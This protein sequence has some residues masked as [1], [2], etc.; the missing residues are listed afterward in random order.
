MREIVTRRGPGKARAP[1]PASA[2]ERLLTPTTGAGGSIAHVVTVVAV[3]LGRPRQGLE[4]EILGRPVGFSFFPVVYRDRGWTLADSLFAV[5]PWAVMHGA[6]NGFVAEEHRVES[7]AFLRQA[8]DFYTTAAEHLSANPLLF[9]YA[10]LNV[11]KALLRTRGFTDSLDH[12]HHG[13]GEARPSDVDLSDAAVKTPKWGGDPQVFPELQQVLGYA[14]SRKDTRLPVPE[15]LAQVVVGHRQWRDGSGSHERFIPIEE[16][17]FMKNAEAREVWVRFY[18][19]PSNLSRFNIRVGDFAD[20]GGLT[21]GGFVAVRSDR[22]GWRCYEQ[23]A[24]TP[25]RTDPADVLDEVVRSV[26]PVLWRIATSHPGSTYRKYYVHLT[27]PASRPHRVGQLPA[28]WASLFYFGSMV[29]YRPQIFESLIESQYGPFVSEF[30]SAQ[31][32]QM[33][34]LLA[35]EM[36]R[37]EVANPAI[38]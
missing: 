9:Y 28:L 2:R 31:P 23:V 12:A 21:A 33:L 5:S 36:C 22:P 35:S 24:A 30:V 29:R 25:F 8:R 34:Y 13:L 18:V 26:R 20:H 3:A 15:L 37:R 4:L 17:V 27:P 6:V 14:R 32:E 16:I 10:F 11:G 7:R 19:D 1:A 38:A